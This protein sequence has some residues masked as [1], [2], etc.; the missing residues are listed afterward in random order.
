M[1]T[2]AR[3]FPDKHWHDLYPTARIIDEMLND[4]DRCDSEMD[5]PSCE[6]C[7]LAYTEDEYDSKDSCSNCKHTFEWHDSVLKERL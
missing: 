3:I 7:D 4:L 1:D 6:D 5:Q 2:A